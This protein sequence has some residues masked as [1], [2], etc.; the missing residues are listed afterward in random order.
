[1]DAT[2]LAGSYGLVGYV[3]GNAPDAFNL[4]S[5]GTVTL[6]ADSTYSVTLT[7]NNDVS[8]S[9]YADSYTGTFVVTEDGKATFTESTGKVYA[10][11]V[12]TDGSIVASLI[13]G[14]G[15][16]GQ[17]SVWVAQKLGASYSMP[18]FA[19]SY[20]LVGFGHWGYED[21]YVAYAG[22]GTFTADGAWSATHT[23]NFDASDTNQT[24]TASGT[25]TV[26]SNGEMA[27]YSPGHDG[28]ATGYVAAD[29]TFAGVSINN[30]DT[31]EI[32]WGSQLGGTL[33]TASVAGIYGFVGIGHDDDGGASTAT[34]APSS[35]TPTAR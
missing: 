14:A 12:G 15:S 17:E 28:P 13:G 33:G 26:G 30:D 10:S 24:V 16:S 32:F 7:H 9:P 6:A 5:V 34:T 4:C 2:S 23:V 27:S 3:H 31:E 25:Y 11:Y 18:T 35:S 21:A 20:G 22:T 1:M 8:D 19:A 29:G